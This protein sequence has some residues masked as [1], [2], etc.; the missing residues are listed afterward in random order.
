LGV[1]DFI[2]IWTSR[3]LFIFLMGPHP[4]PLLIPFKLIPSAGG[5]FGVSGG[6]LVGIIE[7]NY[8]AYQSGWM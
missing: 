4:L 7:F 8:D 3:I 5:F 1:N 6:R 2:V